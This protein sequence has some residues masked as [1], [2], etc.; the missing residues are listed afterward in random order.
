MTAKH[1][2]LDRALAAFD[3]EGLLDDRTIQKVRG[4]AL[5]GLYRELERAR[6]RETDGQLVLGADSERVA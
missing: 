3:T 6:Q 4:I 1:A 2:A 5:G